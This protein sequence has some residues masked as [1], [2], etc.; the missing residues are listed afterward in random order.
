MSKK[1][2][3]PTVYKIKRPD[4]PHGNSVVFWNIHPETWEIRFRQV[5]TPYMRVLMGDKSAIFVLATVEFDD[6]GLQ[7]PDLDPSRR[8][9]NI[10][11]EVPDELW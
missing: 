10:M 3:T 1:Y 8:Y 6:R 11:N 5:P 7:R 2:K 4:N 9:L